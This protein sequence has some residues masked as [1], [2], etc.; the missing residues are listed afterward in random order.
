MER[1]R[2]PL[3]ALICLLGA[4]GISTVSDSAFGAKK[5]PNSTEP[6]DIAKEPSQKDWKRFINSS[7]TRRLKFWSYFAK[8]GKGFRD[9]NWAWRVG[10]VRSC[11]LSRKKYCAQILSYGLFDKAMVVRSE[12]AQRVGQRYE[13]TKDPLAIKLLT[14]AYR[15]KANSRG[16]KPLFVQKRI[17]YALRQIGGDPARTAAATL[18][19]DHPESQRYWVLLDGVNDRG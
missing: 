5:R 8:R 13:N 6:I 4:L 14:K 15:N 1:V 2:N 3:L 17:L 12:A 7:E 19:K 16:G 18:A 10:W 9:W 11:T